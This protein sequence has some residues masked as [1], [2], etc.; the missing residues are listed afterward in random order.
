MSKED[1]Y[2]SCIELQ[3]AGKL[4]EAIESLLKLCAEHPV[5]SLPRLALSVFYAKN[6][7]FEES[8]EHGKKYCEMEPEDP[9]GYTSLSSLALKAGDRDAAEDALVR[10]RDARIAA[11]LREK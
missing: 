2:D 1:W 10:A 11:Q 6:E 9:F 8:L 7:Q 5:Y 4:D 3:R